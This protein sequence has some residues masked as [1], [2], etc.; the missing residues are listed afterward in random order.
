GMLRREIRIG[1]SEES[2]G[3]GNQLRIVIAC[4]QRFAEVG[5]SGHGVDVGIIR[6]P[7]VRV[8][9]EGGNLLDLRQQ[10]LV[11]LLHIGTR[12]RAGLGVRESGQTYGAH[13][14]QGKQK[15]FSHEHVSLLDGERISGRRYRLS[16]D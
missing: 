4:A 15:K 10:T 2:F 7:W 3:R 13:Y 14:R 12:K 6:K 5:R 8:M 9:V 1:I 11:D 16:S